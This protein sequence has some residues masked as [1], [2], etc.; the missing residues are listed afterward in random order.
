MMK[1][2]PLTHLEYMMLE[3]IAKRNKKKPDRLLK[4]FM[5]EHLNNF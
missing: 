1:S 3:E 2:I 5:Y 4:E